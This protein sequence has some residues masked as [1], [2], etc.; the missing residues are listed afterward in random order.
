MANQRPGT[1]ASRGDRMAPTPSW[2]PAEEDYWRESYSSRPYAGREASFDDYSPAYRFGTEN[3]SRFD[4]ASFDEVEDDLSREWE[5]AKG[6]SRLAWDKAK[7][8]VK[9]A[10]QRTSDAIERATPGDSDRDGK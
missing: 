10:W 6:K 5:A 4:G 9:D 8:A 2:N 1:G 3:Y 7:H